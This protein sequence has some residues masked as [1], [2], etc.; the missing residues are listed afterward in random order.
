[1]DILNE[2]SQINSKSRDAWEHF[3]SH[4]T[5]VT[6]LIVHVASKLPSS[7]KIENG[8]PSLAIFGAGNGNDLNV[9][10]LLESFGRIHIFDLDQ[11]ALKRFQALHCQSK[12]SKEVIQIENPIDLSGVNTELEQYP[13][14]ATDAHV[15][16][17]ANKARTAS[18]VSIDR[19]FDVVASTCMLSQLLH[20]VLKSV[21]DQHPHKNFL[22]IALRD[23]H[24]KLMSRAIRPGGI[25]LLVT[26][27]VSSDTLP[28][29][30][31]AKDDETV[32]A[33]ARQA[34]DARNFFTGTLPWAIKDSLATMLLESADQP[35]AIHSPW[36]WLLG[37]KRSYLVTAI[38]FAK[39]F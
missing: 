30:Q 33:I 31:E 36:K 27:F 8:R 2:Q 21:G 19:Q 6:D 24:L 9:E 20:S 32:L 17:V 25:G 22:M 26:D 39:T 18:G 11:D 4:R 14:S 28:A 3:D 34:I 38:E 29:L 5:R 16:T 37:P 15:E 1:M 12:L 10:R 23:G 13:Q 7:T 35:W